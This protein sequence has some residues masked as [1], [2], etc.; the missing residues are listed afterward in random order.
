MEGRR[1][2]EARTSRVYIIVVIL[3]SGTLA[4]FSWQMVHCAPTVLSRLLPRG[5]TLIF[6]G[7]MLVLGLGCAY[8]AAHGSHS[9]EEMLMCFVQ[10]FMGLWFMLAVSAQAR[11]SYE[12]EQM[13]R[14]VYGMIGILCSYHLLA[15]RGFSARHGD[16]Q[17]GADRGRPLGDDELLQLPR[18]RRVVSD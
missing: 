6:G 12:D 14:R 10:G 9:A 17:H 1:W 2:S 5:L 18:W 7:G 16:P 13:L 3:L 11:G 4:L 8:V 15:V